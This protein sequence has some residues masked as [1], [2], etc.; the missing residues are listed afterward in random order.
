MKDFILYPEA[1]ELK[2]LGFDEPSFAWYHLGDTLLSDITIGYEKTDFLY[3]QDDMEETQCTAP[4]YSQAFRWFREKYDLHVQ[5]RKENYFQERKYEYYH[6]DISKGEENDITKQ[7]DLLYKILDECSQ[8]IPGNHLDH[9]M[10]S[11]L[12]IEKEFAFKTYEE[13][14]LRCLRHLIKIVKEN[15]KQI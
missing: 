8:D 1:L 6:F 13:A 9:D 7:E 3:T 12:I 14:E 10:Y 4:T 2:Q 15:E 5:I 11:K